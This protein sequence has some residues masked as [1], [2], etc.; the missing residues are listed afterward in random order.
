M[1]FLRKN[2]L[3]YKILIAIKDSLIGGLK[4]GLEVILFPHQALKGFSL[5]YDPVFAAKFTKPQ[6]NRGLFQ[7]K[8][9]GYLKQKKQKGKKI[10]FNLTSKGKLEIIRY[11]IKMDKRKLPW[12]GKWRIIIF[13]VPEISRKDRDFLRNQLRWLGFMELQ[14]SVWIF[15]YEIKSELKEFIKLCRLKL[16]GDVRFLTAEDID[17]D[18]DIKKY[19]KLK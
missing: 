7:L 16:K 4:G 10:Y 13:D 1:K 17:N 6:F 19:F 5:Y 3:S 14:K 15:P 8:K 2:S 11:I 9:Q 12:D 18:K